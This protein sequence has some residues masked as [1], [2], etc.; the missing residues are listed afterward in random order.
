MEGDGWKTD[1]DKK[2]NCFIC[3]KPDGWLKFIERGII[4]LSVCMEC[5]ALGARWVVNRGREEMEA[6]KREHEAP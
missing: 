3:E 1:D 5:V 6:R 2:F 4:R